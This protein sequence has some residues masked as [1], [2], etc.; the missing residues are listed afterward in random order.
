M[1][2]AAAACHTMSLWCMC[3]SCQALACRMCDCLYMQGATC[4]LPRLAGCHISIDCFCR[5]GV[6]LQSRRCSCRISP[7]PVAT[8]TISAIHNIWAEPASSVHGLVCCLKTGALVCFTVPHA[9]RA[10]QWTATGSPHH[11]T[12]VGAQGFRASWNNLVI[13]ITPH[14]SNHHLRLH[15]GNVFGWCLRPFSYPGLKHTPT[16]S[17]LAT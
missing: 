5:P 11:C 3:S 4:V 15:R 9:P 16:H 14:A 12:H 8:Q 13:I 10:S 6:W 1:L 2:G 7:M 17:G